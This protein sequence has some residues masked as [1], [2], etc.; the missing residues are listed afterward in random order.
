M[1]FATFL[2]A[3]KMGMGYED[4]VTSAFT[5]ASNNFELA[6]AVAVGAPYRTHCCLQSASAV[7]TVR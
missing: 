1:F 7:S 6:I 3:H 2:V 5:A 4:T